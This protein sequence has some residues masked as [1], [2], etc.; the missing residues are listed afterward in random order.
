VRTILYALTSHAGQTIARQWEEAEAAGFRLDH[1]VIDEMRAAALP[2]AQRP[3]GSRLLALLRRGDVLLVNRL[4]RLGRSYADVSEAIHALLARDVTV[5]TIVEE[6]TF[7]SGPTKSPIQQAM[8]DS[9]IA[10][11]A[12]QTQVDLKREAL[13][14]RRE[15]EREDDLVD[16]LA[17]RETARLQAKISLALVAGM[18]I[19]AYVIAFV[20][21]VAPPR[22]WPLAQAGW[23]EAS[24]P[25]THDRS[26]GAGE[27]A[28]NPQREAQERPAVIAQYEAL[29][30]DET[31]QKDVSGAEELAR[32]R[33]A[34]PARSPPQPEAGQ[35]E[36]DHPRAAAPRTE[37]P[38]K[39]EQAAAPDS[40]RAPQDKT[41][42][43]TFSSPPP[44]EERKIRE[45]VFEWRSAR[46]QRPDFPVQVGGAVPRHIHLATF[47]RGLVAQMPRYRGYKFIVAENRIA[48]IDPATYR[49][50]AVIG[51]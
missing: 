42:A 24:A 29:S 45:T 21:P 38:A 51:E 46:V 8:R 50:V 1:V 19:G 28:Q 43:E 25:R 33:R 49:I 14:R 48:V 31:M 30:L 11:A 4:D 44:G 26:G 39:P 35:V 40:A 17:R 3:E 47:P 37:E 10:F 15:A 41:P 9:L 2:F 20:L 16:P 13:R 27:A 6:L 34:E 5:K 18:S 36:P 32:P 12:A 23:Q 7:E 22:P